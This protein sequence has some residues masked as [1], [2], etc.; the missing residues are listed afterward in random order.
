MEQIVSLVRDYMHAEADVC[1]PFA[2]PDSV[3]PGDE[4]A[5]TISR[6]SRQRNGRNFWRRALGLPALGLVLAPDAQEQIL[7]AGRVE[8]SHGEVP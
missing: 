6:A 7:R 2:A 5:S 8:S 1:L 3:D 4:L